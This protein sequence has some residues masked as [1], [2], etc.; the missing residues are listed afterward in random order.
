MSIIRHVADPA[1]RGVMILAGSI[2]SLYEQGEK[3]EA[4][5][6]GFQQLHISKRKQSGG[7]I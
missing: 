1:E 5:E 4:V 7:S 3:A 6:Y 2:A